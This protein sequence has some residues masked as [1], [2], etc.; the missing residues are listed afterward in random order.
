MKRRNP[1]DIDWSFVLDPDERLHWA[2]RPEY[3]CGTFQLVGHEPVWYAGLAAGIAAM[4]ASMPF[5]RRYQPPDASEAVWIYGVAT[6]CFILIGCYM[7]IGRADVLGSLDYAVTDQR[8]IVC[9]HGRD[10]LMRRRRYVVSCP[11]HPSWDFPILPGRPL[12]SIRVGSA[13]SGEAVQPFGYGLVHPGWPVLWGR[14]LMPVLFENVSD[15]QGVRDVLRSA[16]IARGAWAVGLDLAMPRKRPTQ[17]A[18]LE[19]CRPVGVI[20]R[21]CRRC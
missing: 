15:A 16:A 13:L 2:G 4:W 19:T 7:A 10:P 20:I 17:W 9:R 14:V 12:S 6:V 1:A 5:I 18:G 21:G 8:A 11:L 3:G